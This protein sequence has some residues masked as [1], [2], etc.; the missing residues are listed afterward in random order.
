MSDARPS[1]TAII[2]M[3][4]HGVRFLQQRNHRQAG[5]R[6]L[7]ALSHL[8]ESNKKR[9]LPGKL[10]QEDEHEI[11]ISGF[12]CHPISPSTASCSSSAMGRDDRTTSLPFQ[13][14]DRVFAFSSSQDPTARHNR[15]GSSAM[16]L[17][18]LGVTNHARAMELSQQGRPSKLSSAKALKMYTWALSAVQHWARGHQEAVHEGCHLLRLAILNN[19][20]HINAMMHRTADAQHCLKCTRD[21]LNYAKG[22]VSREEYAFFSANVVVLCLKGDSGNL[23][24][25][26]AAAA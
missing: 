9:P 3:N 10:Q 14:F 25:A 4:N 7:Q 12:S 22:H 18:N 16:L 5:D 21:I 6:I 15:D 1:S 23:V 8:K 26:P 2:A 19:M 13:M 20:A 11:L 17:Y 24:K